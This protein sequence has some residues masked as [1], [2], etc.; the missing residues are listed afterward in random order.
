MDHLVALEVSVKEKGHATKQ[1][2]RSEYFEK[3]SRGFVVRDGN[4]EP[5]QAVTPMCHQT[6]K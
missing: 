6:K 2:E 1:N 5:A 4:L 3:Y